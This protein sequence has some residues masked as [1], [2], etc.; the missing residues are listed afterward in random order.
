MNITTQSGP[1]G[2]HKI[3]STFLIW[4]EFWGLKPAAYETFSLYLF[5]GWEL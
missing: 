5:L 4:P 1:E 2:G 3:K